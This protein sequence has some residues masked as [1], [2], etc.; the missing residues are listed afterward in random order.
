[1]DLCPTYSVVIADDHPLVRLGIKSFLMNEPKFRIVGEA[2]NGVEAIELIENLSPDIAIVDIVMP[3]MDGISVARHL[4]QSPNNTRIV[5][6]TAIEEFIDAPSAFFSG[7]DGILSKNI[8]QSSFIDSL[9]QVLG[10][11]KVYCT[12]VLQFILDSGKYLPK[13]NEILRLTK[14]QQKIID[15]R[16][17][18]Y[19][20]SEIAQELNLTM[21]QIASEISQIIDTLDDY[22]IL[23]KS[24]VSSYV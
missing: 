21:P 1:M 4:Q 17:R 14:L 20:F 23:L 8:S 16:L 7:A 3:V 2:S 10:G 19:L 18:G 11:K 22:E 15:R 5:L 9:E 24:T 13:N 12:S 6:I